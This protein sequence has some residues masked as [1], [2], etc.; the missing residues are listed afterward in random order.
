[1]IHPPI[2]AAIEAFTAEGSTGAFVGVMADLQQRG[3]HTVSALSIAS[4]VSKDGTVQ[5]MEED[6]NYRRMRAA[7]I[8]VTSLGRRMIGGDDITTYTDQEINTAARRFSHAGVVMSL[9]EHPLGLIVATGTETPVI[10]S[11]YRSA[12]KAES[13]AVQ[14]LSDA[15]NRGVVAW[16]TTDSVASQ[17]AYGAV[18]IPE[19][20]IHVIHN[21][22]DTERFRESPESRAEIRRELEIPDE[23]PVIAFVSRFSNMA[24]ARYGDEKNTPLFIKSAKAYLEA[25]DD[26]HIIMAGSGLDITNPNLQGLLTTVFDGRTELLRR[27]HALGRRNDVE[28]IY[29][30]AD[31]AALTSRTESYPL[32]LLEA[33]A[34]GITAVSTDVG[35]SRIILEGHGLIAPA[36]PEAMAAAWDEAYRRR[37]EL[38]V[39][40]EQRARY[41]KR[42]M[43]NGYANLINQTAA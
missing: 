16:C 39:P 41:D 23:S 8:V 26:R 40:P 18:G 33:L 34:T 32:C 24:D 29:A 37:H 22:I 1:M 38:A 3:N 4:E 13:L 36:N 42:E 2:E 15:I 17:R 31:V 6:S 19:S 28:K 10:A 14:G 43:V 25:G 9:Q 30:A 21:G 35:D 5:P 20:R 7:G 11:L 12:P 27:I